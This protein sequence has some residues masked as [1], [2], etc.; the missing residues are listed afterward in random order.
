MALATNISGLMWNCYLTV[1]SFRSRSL[2]KHLS[3]TNFVAEYLIESAWRITHSKG[4]IYAAFHNANRT[5]FR[6]E[7]AAL[8]NKGSGDG[9]F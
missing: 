9:I 7:A 6:M 4:P 8:D 1:V 2:L 5:K 3:Y